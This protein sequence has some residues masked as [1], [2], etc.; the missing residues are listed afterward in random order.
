M[1]TEIRFQNLRSLRDTGFIKLKPINLLIGANSSGKSTFLRAFLLLSQSRKKHM[2]VPIAWFDDT[3]VDFGDFDTSKNSNAKEDE[4]IIFS[5]RFS[6]LIS[7][8]APISYFF[9]R[10]IINVSNPLDCYECNIYY[11]IDSKKNVYVSQL[12]FKS[13]EIYANL[14]LPENGGE[15]CVVINNKEVNR[16]LL[17][18]RQTGEGFLLP[19]IFFN[20]PPEKRTNRGLVIDFEVIDLA[21]GILKSQ[22]GA[23]FSNVE[24]LHPI[25]RLWRYNKE[26]FLYRL[27]SFRDIKS[28]H[29]NI[30][31]W[32][33]ETQIFN[34]LYYR[35]LILYLWD[36]MRSVDIE[37]DSFFE[38]CDYIGPLRAEGKR[39][40][41]NQGLQ[42]K[43][44]DSFG[45]NLIEFIDSLTETQKISYNNFLEN[46]LGVNIKVKN[47]MGHQS[48]ILRLEGRE[49]NIADVGFGYSQILPIITKLWFLQERT[50]FNSF[51]DL[52]F[53]RSSRV[54]FLLEQPELHL[55][56]ALQAKLADA[57]LRVTQIKDSRVRTDCIIETHSPTII[58]RIGRRI[59]EGNYKENNV[60]LLIF[61]KHN[62]NGD[63]TLIQTEYNER[64]QIKN[65]PLGFFDPFDDDF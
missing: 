5:F 51:R 13:G 22:C 46:I 16:D 3:L 15:V 57:F 53:F 8:R 12:N 61:N 49:F 14:I 58:N 56:P 32:T 50:R 45:S 63:T 43:K 62:E 52:N 1:V 35:I 6:N 26:E 48:M 4:S 2:R 64:G 33:L 44:V 29:K 59:R 47:H 19:N 37:L 18:C 28:L 40:Y 36:I 20:L 11:S 10:N 39:Y 21:L 54:T 41:R 24:R 9:R 55:H 30:N 7:N 34:D 17:S 27:K 65:W 23:R 31:K 25:I 38:N 60:N 42:V